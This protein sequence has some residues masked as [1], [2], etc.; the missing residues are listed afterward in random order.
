M[1][2]GVI[3]GYFLACLMMMAKGNTQVDIDYECDSLYNMNKKTTMRDFWLKEK[4]GC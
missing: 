2:I 4:E 3:V 1:V